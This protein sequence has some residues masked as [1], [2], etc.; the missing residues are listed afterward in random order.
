[1]DDVRTDS[2]VPAAAPVAA[3]APM[4]SGK[5]MSGGLVAILGVVLLVIIAAW[6]YAMQSGMFRAGDAG[7]IPPQDTLMDNPGGVAP[8]D[9]A[10]A[11]AEVQ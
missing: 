4:T 5:K 9:G 10:S 11:S 2:S 1:M 6:A 7:G 8:A 3:P